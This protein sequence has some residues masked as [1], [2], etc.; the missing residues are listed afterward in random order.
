MIGRRERLHRRSASLVALFVL[1]PLLPALLGRGLLVD[2][3]ALS[4][5]EP[6]RSEV[7]AAYTGVVT[8]RGDTIDYYLPGIAEIKRSLFAGHFPTWAPYEVGGAPLASLPNHGVLSPMSLPYL[9]LPLWLAPAYVK[10]LELSGGHRGHGP[11]LAQA[12]AGPDRR[13]GRRCRV[14]RIRVHAHVDQLAAHPRGCA[15]PG[16]VLGTGT[17]GPGSPRS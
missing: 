5:F 4:A 12:G 11:L 9:L 1:V 14:R 8:C 16:D 6:F 13:P 10:L 2:V 3:G 7:G 17:A 15:D